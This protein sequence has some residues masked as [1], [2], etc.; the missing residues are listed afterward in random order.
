MN[1]ASRRNSK[2]RSICTE[3]ELRERLEG[4]RIK[5]LEERSRRIRPLLDDKILTDWNGLMAAAFARAGAVLD[6]SVFIERAETAVDFLNNSLRAKDGRLLHRYRLGEAAIPAFLD[7][8]VFLTWALLELYDAT[9]EVRYLERAIDL[10]DETISRFWDPKGGGFFFTA[11]DN[12]A[13]LVRSKEVYDGAI[14]SGNSV[15]M[16]NLVRLAHLTGKPGLHR[17]R[18]RAAKGLRCGC[19]RALPRPTPTSSTACNAPPPPPS[20]SS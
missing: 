6:D 20:R 11:P 16:N 9:L 13:L 5:L 10:Q 12:E 19:R 4:M 1:G 7:D 18:K 3:D 15:A 2:E 14:P 17:A 8:H